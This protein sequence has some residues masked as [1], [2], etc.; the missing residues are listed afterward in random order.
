MGAADVVPG[1]SGGTIA[2]ITGIYYELLS[3]LKSL[4]P[5]AL[6]TLFRAGPKAFW[7]QING[8]FLFSLFG[9]VL[10]SIKTFAAVIGYALENHPLL[11]WG[12]FTGLIIASVFLLLRDQH[13]W[14]LKHWCL[15]ILGA[16][17]V[18]IISVLIFILMYF[19]VKKLIIVYYGRKKSLSFSKDLARTMA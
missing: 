14:S 4:T 17:I 7:K 10:L 15:C 19:L 18:V 2:L 16:L 5:L 1:V 13:G 3:S 12:F 8:T 6:L 11:V 9:G